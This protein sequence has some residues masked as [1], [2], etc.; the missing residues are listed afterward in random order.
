MLMSL[1]HSQQPTLPPATIVPNL[2]PAKTAE[3]VVT[4]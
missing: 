3:V 1:S 2:V 4:R